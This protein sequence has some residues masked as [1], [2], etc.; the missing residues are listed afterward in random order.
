MISLH[1][2]H[3]TS[4]TMEMSS[5]SKPNVFPLSV[6]NSL[7]FCE[8]TSLW[9]ISSLASNWACVEAKYITTVHSKHTASTYHNCFEDLSCDRWENPLIIVNS[10]IS[11]DVWKGLLVGTKQNTK[12]NIN[13]LQVCERIEKQH[14]KTAVLQMVHWPLLP[15]TTGIRRG[16]LRM[17]KM[18]GFWTQGMRKWVPSPLTVWRT[19]RKRSNITARSPPSTK[20][21]QLVRCCIY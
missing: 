17:L 13:I 7:T 9:V 3:D 10:N 19:P 8:T 1:S 6:S 5:N 12:S 4:L 21:F 20:P 11:I 14:R 18:I 15:V 16:R 2:L